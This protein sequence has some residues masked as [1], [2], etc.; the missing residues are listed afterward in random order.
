MPNN[1]KSE[2][3]RNLEAQLWKIA[4][5]LR[6]KMDANE[7]KNYM[8]GFI[9]Y[10]Y[11]SEKLENFAEEILKNDGISF[12]KAYEDKKYRSTL[13]NHIKKNLGYFLKPECL[14]NSIVSGAKTK[15][16][17]IKNLNK[18]LTKIEESAV[19]EDSE[20]DFIHLFDDVELTSSKLGKDENEINELIS[21]VLLNLDEID[22]RLD[23]DSAD[24]L[25][26]AYEYLISQFA[27]EAGKKAGEFYTPKEVSIVLAKIVSL[28]KDQIKNVY[29]AT[30]G[31]G[32]LLLRVGKETR[33]GDYYGQELNQTTYNLA[34]M[35]MTLHGKWFKDFDIQQGD[36]L[37]NPQ[38]M[39]M[40]DEGGFEAIVANPPFSAHWSADEKF[41]KDPRFAKYGKLA[42]KKKA[43][44][45][46]VQHM[47]Y[48]LNKDNGVMAIVLPHGVLFRGAS[49]QIIRKYLLEDKNYVDAIIGMPPNLFYGTTIPTVVLVFKKNRNE[50][51]AIL[52]IDASKNYEK[53]KNQNFLREEDINKIIDTYR[54]RKEIEKYS[55]NAT[56]DEIRENEYNLNIPRYVD[57]FEEEEP[58]DL[59]EV[60]REIREID[61][62]S[63]E[64]DEKIRI[65]CDELGIES[66][67]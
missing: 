16:F 39:E 50:D 1:G 35:N 25:G 40:I 43:D 9:F 47:I 24:I 58:I 27:S 2:Y 31:S 38:H 63:L 65:Y 32:S 8:L 5:L 42:P 52:F 12:A 49:E 14:F 6:G 34:R 11:L 66:P 26:D 37:N 17:I 4:D 59:K 36:S 30:C 48:L 57:T 22:F 55:H 18:A 46:F 60:V 56:I 23:D 62:K 44:Y 20:E 51:D 21:K 54:D 64:I 7:Y 19:G 28:G 15:K 45:A 33:V 3:K 41:L 29:D 67:F 61:K 53:V 10:K 13:E